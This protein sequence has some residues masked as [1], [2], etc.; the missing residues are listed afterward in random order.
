MIDI[1]NYEIKIL[2]YEG[3]V[4]NVYFAQNV[5][6]NDYVII[7]K[8]PNTDDNFDYIIRDTQIP[9]LLKHPNIIEIKEIIKNDDFV[10]IIY[11]YINNSICL[12]DQKKN[13]LRMLNIINDICDAIEFMHS[14]G[15]VHRDIKPDNIICSDELN[16]II[17]FDMAAILEDSDLGIQD[18]LVGT[19]IYIAPEL[20][21]SSENI[22]YKMADVYSLGITMYCIFNNHRFPYRSRKIEDVEFDLRSKKPKPSRTGHKKL[23]KLIMSMISKNPLDRPKIEEIQNTLKSLIKSFQL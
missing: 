17:D 7:K 19:P 10:Y 20:W 14:K 11:P 15:V 23:D 9:N 4:T 3:S 5:K 8:I 21:K 18:K 6:N 1:E 22:N 13:K 12:V 2:I 16:F